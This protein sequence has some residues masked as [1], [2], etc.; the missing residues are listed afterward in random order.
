VTPL[1]ITADLH[2]HPF[3]LNS[4]DGGRDRLQDGLSALRQS[5]EVARQ[6]GGVWVFAGDMKVPRTTWVQEALNGAI[7]VFEEFPEVR[8]VLLP[9]NH[10]GPGLPGGSGLRAFAPMEGVELLGVPTLLPA[11]E[12]GLAAWPGEADDAGLD[13]FVEQARREGCGLLLGHGLFTGSVLSSGIAGVGLDP[14]R[15]GIGD[16]FELAV[17]GDVHRGQIFNQATG[18]RAFDAGAAVPADEEG[19]YFVDK[20]FRGQIVYPGDPYQQNWGEA[21]EVPK[22]VLVV[23][24]GEELIGLAELEGPRY[25]A[26]DWSGEAADVFVAFVQGA[27][28]VGGQS[29][30]EAWRGNFVRLLLPEWGDAK[31][32]QAEM[33]GLPDRVGTRSFQAVVQRRPPAERRT[34]VHAGMTGRAL[35]GQYMKA[36]PPQDLGD[37][38]AVMEAGMRL[39]GGG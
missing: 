32:V 29:V 19:S 2:L 9:G 7:A 24:P 13:A 33:K 6:I 22:G 1:V 38:L 17:F 21:G 35:L 20:R 36:K 15:F 12:P 27:K 10:D 3:R 34:E 4:R 28:T 14:A 39:W 30:E 11:T 31:A 8:K 16:A 25:L 26:L 18:W 5:L 23:E 37:P